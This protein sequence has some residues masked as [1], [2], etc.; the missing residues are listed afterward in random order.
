[1]H[2]VLHYYYTLALFDEHTALVSYAMDIEP[3]KTYLHDPL[4]RGTPGLIE[5]LCNLPEAVRKGAIAHVVQDAYWQVFVRSRYQVHGNIRWHRYVEACW[6]RKWARRR[7]PEPPMIETDELIN[8][9]KAFGEV[10]EDYVKRMNKAIIDSIY[11]SGW[12]ENMFPEYK[13]MDISKYINM[14]DESFD[15]LKM[16]D[17]VKHLVK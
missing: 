16:N 10:D 14:I 3:A 4:Y 17:L 6:S 15:E 13:G 2:T 9:L 5:R 12:L 11:H 7:M 8:I 1:M